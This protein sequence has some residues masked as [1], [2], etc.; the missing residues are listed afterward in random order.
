MC[1]TGLVLGAALPRWWAPIAVGLFVGISY[2]LFGTDTL[3]GMRVGLAEAYGV[4][5]ALAA[6]FGGGFRRMYDRADADL[7]AGVDDVGS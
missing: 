3:P 5:S 6:S 2:R 7:N 4:L 1:I